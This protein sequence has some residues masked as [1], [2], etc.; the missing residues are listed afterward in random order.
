ME[1]PECP[2]CLESYDDAVAIPRVLSCGPTVCEPCLAELHQRYPNTIRCPAC[3]R[4]VKYQGP[5]SLPK[6][7][8]LLRLCLQHSS[9]SSSGNQPRKPSHRSAI[10]DD[11]RRRFWS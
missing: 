2:V 5:S 6:N 8:D 11:D 9:S 7:I 3:T 10:A 4:L 1:L